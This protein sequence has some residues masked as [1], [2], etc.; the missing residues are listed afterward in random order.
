MVEEDE[1]NCLDRP[2][3]L[4]TDVGDAEESERRG[5]IEMDRFGARFRVR[6]RREVADCLR[7]LLGETDMSLNRERGGKEGV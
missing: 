1:E 5:S 4:E 3:S 7:N 2:A 6:E